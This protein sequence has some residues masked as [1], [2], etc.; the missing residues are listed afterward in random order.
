AGNLRELAAIVST[1]RGLGF[2]HVSFLPLDASSAAFGGHPERRAAL[3]PSA[4]AVAAFR[5]SVDALEAEGALADGFVLESAAKLELLADHLDASAG[6][7]SFQRPA[8][9]APW[10]SSV[11]EADGALRPCFFH[12]AVGDARLGV[13]AMRRSPAYREA[14]SR[15]R[16]PNET[17]SRCV[18]PKRGAS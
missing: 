8:C 6:R 18:C 5:R 15:I 17:C 14:L 11:V 1:A 13:G 9:D 2:D 7:G 12:E 4:T 3:V 16:R 10:W